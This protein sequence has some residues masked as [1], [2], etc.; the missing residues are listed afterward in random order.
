M[1]PG[2]GYPAVA[3]SSTR[4]Q[5]ISS[6][7][8]GGVNARSPVFGNVPISIAAPVRGLNHHPIMFA[9]RS[10]PTR[11]VNVRLTGA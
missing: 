2:A 3:S 10:A 9:P 4:I 8:S 5:S 6:P 1:K 11:T 7:A